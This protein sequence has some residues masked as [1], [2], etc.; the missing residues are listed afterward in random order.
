MKER[1]TLY[2]EL[3]RIVVPKLNKY[4]PHKPTPQQAAFLLLECKEALYGGAAGGGKSNAL[5]SAALQHVD[6]PE[7]SAI[8]FRRT[9]ADLALPGALMDRAEEWLKGT[10]ARWNEKKKQWKF[11]SGA[12]LTFG[13]M[14]H[15]KDRYRYQSSEFQFVGFDELTQFT[16][17]QYTYMFSRLRRL[18]DSK[19]RLRMRAA[20]NPGGEGHDWVKHRYFT[21]GPKKKRFFIPAKLADNPHLDREEYIESLNELDAITRQQLLDGDW[22]AKHGGS[23]F[24]KE[25]FE[26]V[27]AAPTNLRIVRS[28]DLAAT[29]KKKGKDPCN[30]AGVKMGVTPKGIYYIMDCRAGQWSPLNTENTI[31]QTAQL[32]GKRVPIY[33]EEEGGSGGKITIDH[34]VREVLAG[35]TCYGER[36]GAAK[37]ER[38]NPFS[39]Q[40]QAGNVKIV[41][42]AWNEPYL[43]ELEGFPN[44]KKDRVDASSLCFKKLTDNPHLI[45]MV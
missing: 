36:P 9:F 8:L 7:Y 34:Y 38:C 32:D 19:V 17:L 33:I 30:T 10:D 42:G 31:K 21:E 29:E 6:V 25:W 15:E 5:L 16:K 13:Y 11:P 27:E 26:I 41:R 22:S 1:V 23:K 24:K 40:C 3:K 18:K 20:S 44:G 35:W 39:S 2:P 43:D 4:I 14:E 45:A 28:W 12:R 37:E